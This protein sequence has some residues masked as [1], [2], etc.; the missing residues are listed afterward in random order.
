MLSV[1]FFFLM[2]EEGIYHLSVVY[3]RKGAIREST[4]IRN[5]LRVRKL[6]YMMPCANIPGQ[7]DH[8]PIDS[9]SDIKYTP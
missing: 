1:F 2:R 9:A 8:F 6:D 4:M 5:G 3:F 7:C